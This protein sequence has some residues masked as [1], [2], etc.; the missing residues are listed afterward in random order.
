MIWKKKKIKN[1]YFYKVIHL[2]IANKIDKN[3]L[4]ILPKN[5]G[6]EKYRTELEKLDNEKIIVRAEDVPFFTELISKKRNCIGLTG[7]DLF[8]E[9][10][11]KNKN[12]KVQVVQK[13][14]WECENAIFQCP[15]LCL[16]GKEDKKLE[17]STV[18]VN[19]KYSQITDQYFSKYRYPK[20]ILYFNGSTETAVTIG[21]ADFVIDIVYSGKS[22]KEAGLDIL[23]KIF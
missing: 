20:N 12:S 10:N 3:C 6:L 18:A 17:N 8:I 16:L 23:A 21:I 7:E 5:S 1:N 14:P 9:Y 13:I 15:T 19:K 2:F 22:A 4:L 11:L